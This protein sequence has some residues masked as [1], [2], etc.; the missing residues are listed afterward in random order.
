MSVYP[1]SVPSKRLAS[2][3]TSSASSFRVNNILGWDGNA[4]S[5]A[6][7][8][9]LHYVVFR[10]AAGTLME[11]MEIDSSTIASA[12]IT[13]TKRGLDFEG[14]VDE[15]S[16]NKLSWLA[17]ETIVEFGSHPPQ[18][19]RQSYVDLFSAQT[20]AGAKTLS[21]I[22]TF[23]NGAIP[24]LNAAGT[25]G[26]GTEEYFVTKRYAD[27]LALSG[28]PDGSTT[29]KG[30]YEE[31]TQAE[32]EAGTASGSTSARLVINPSTNGA[33]LYFGYAADAGANDTYAITCAPVPTAYTTG[34]VIQFKANTANTGAC[35][36]NVN[37]L[38]AKSLK[39]HKD[40][41]PQD[42]YIKAG[43]L[44]T[45]IYDGTNFQILSVSG[46]PTV[47]QTGEEIYAASTTGNDTYAITV[48]PVP[49][50]Y[51][52][53][54]RLYFK[55]DTANTGAATLNV[56]SLGAKS[57]LRPDGSALADGDVAANQII[58][59]AYDGTNFLMITPVSNA[60]I[61]K[62]GTTTKDASDASTTQNIAHGLGRAPRKVKIRAIYAAVVGGG[63]TGPQFRFAETVYNGT[64]QSSISAYDNGSNS[65][66]FDATFTL[67]AGDNSS[68]QVGVVT[69]DATNIIITWT[70][71]G[72][73]TG[74]YRLLWEAEA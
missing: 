50:A 21:A 34:M 28:A 31:A 47:S 60:P 22:W 61:Y 32:I 3:I 64:T 25:W 11:I 41:D 57:I 29:Q 56:N 8:G 33:R 40:L 70:K 30:I 35:T 49:A 24:R 12:S 1:I 23:N 38:G 2:S 59:V 10:N 52:T 18:L 67:N 27:A 6:D 42:G 14:N 46:K 72:S 17:N 73:P 54:M 39:I 44:V 7:L 36:L 16:A 62:N 37:T 74:T 53:G 15:V 63:S 9:T 48:A 13:I 68:T 51:A 4:I 20:I 43:Q 71:T 55:P 58:G 26:A 19:F 66:T 65:M 45:V 5:A 69:F